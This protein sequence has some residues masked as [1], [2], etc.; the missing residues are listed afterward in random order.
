M[1]Q[2]EGGLQ[3]ELELELELEPGWRLGSALLELRETDIN[4]A[5]SGIGQRRP[6]PR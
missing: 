6:F 2:G 4:G 5:S 1:P 3:L